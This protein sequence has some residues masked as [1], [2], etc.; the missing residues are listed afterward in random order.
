MKPACHIRFACPADLPRLVEMEN[1]IF[2]APWS[3]TAIAAELIVDPGR[4]A[5]VAEIGDEVVAYAF[6]WRVVDEIHL[7][8]L[9]VDDRHRRQGIADRLLRTLLRHEFA[10]HTRAM[11]LEVRAS[12]EAALSLYRR[13]GFAEVAIRRGYYPDNREDAVVMVKLLKGSAPQAPQPPRSHDQR[14]ES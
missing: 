6:V 12:N 4:L 1:A 9:A 13:H 2:T 10:R 7:V 8:S 5:L 11:T 3:P 14:K